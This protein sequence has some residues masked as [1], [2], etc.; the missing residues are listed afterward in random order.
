M[1]CA[2]EGEGDCDS[3]NGSLTLHVIERV[4]SVVGTRQDESGSK[5]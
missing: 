5:G 4:R 3:P 2:V 1:T